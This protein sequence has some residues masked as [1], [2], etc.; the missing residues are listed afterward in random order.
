MKTPP[1][2]RAAG[3]RKLAA[4]GQALPG[5]TDPIPNL[6]Y[7]RRAIRSIGRVDPAKR[8]AVKALIIRRAKALKAASAP[9]VKGTWPFQAAHDTEGIELATMT[10]RMPK[11]RGAADVQMSRTA[12][13]VITVAHKSTG[14]KVGTITAAG[15]GY[16]GTHA[17][18][19][20]TPASGSQQGALAGLIAVHNRM[21]AGPGLPPAQRDGTAS[22]A[23]GGQ[24]SVELAGPGGWSH[25]WIHDGVTGDMSH[26]DKADKMSGNAFRRGD[27]SQDALQGHRD[28]AKAHRAA[29]R[30]SGTASGHAYHTAMAGL[31]AK[32]ASM[33][34]ENRD[35]EDKATSLSVPAGGQSVDLAGSLPVTTPAS[36]STD[37]PRITTMGG[38]KASPV[39]AKAG[40]SPYAQQI[41]K[42]LVAKGIKPDAALAMAKRAA[43][44]HA[45]AAA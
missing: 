26:A 24:E 23:A 43:V 12:P 36:S 31:H 35:A 28:A 37:G 42:K 16:E 11:I 21:A 20:K 8:P 4:K 45:K 25:G 17:S 27:G 5:G 6:D 40:L 2:Q 33:K 18:G 44:M 7:L 19:A 1:V 10:R 38:A 30:M 39:M 29:A 34:M 3:R 22:Y 9:G 32:V 15:R 13:G 14:M 41:Y